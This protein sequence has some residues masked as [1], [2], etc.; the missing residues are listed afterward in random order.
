M[1]NHFWSTVVQL[2]QGQI[3]TELNPGLLVVA[4]ATRPTRTRNGNFVIQFLGA[5]WVCILNWVA[6]LTFYFPE[7]HQ[8]A[9]HQ[10][11]AV[12]RYYQIKADAL[13]RI[14]GGNQHT[15]AWGHKVSGSQTWMIFAVLRGGNQLAGLWGSSKGLERCVLGHFW[16]GKF[17]CL[18]SYVS[19]E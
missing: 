1:C 17:L 7:S 9:S 5:V 18:K 19:I 11:V 12:L 6:S 16:L 15:L 8:E 10:G 4:G 2:Y 13:E 14:S 3:A